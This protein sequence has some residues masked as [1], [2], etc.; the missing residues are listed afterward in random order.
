MTWQ[1]HRLSLVGA[2]AV[3]VLTVTSTIAFLV[4]GGTW[5]F[6]QRMQ[7]P[8]R[9]GDLGFGTAG[10]D[11]L[12]LWLMLAAIA[13]TFVVPTLLSTTA[14]AAVVGAAGRERRLAVLRLVGLS[15]RDI[16]AMT[17]LETG[18]QAVMGITLGFLIS[19][20]I[21][22]LFSA[23]SFQNT[24]IG[25]RELYLPWWGY[26]AVAAMVLLLALSAAYLGMRR[27]RVTPLGVAKRQVSPMLKRW[28]LVVFLLIAIPG[29][30]F[31]SH[32]SFSAAAGVVIATLTFLFLVVSAVNLVCP[33]I[34]QL[35]ARIMAL[36][37]GKAHFVATQRVLFDAKAVW[38]RSSATALFGL[39]AGYL[40]ISPLGNDALS[41]IYSQDP[42]SD[43]IFRD[44]STGALLTLGFGFVIM[45]V[46][47]FLGQVSEVFEHAELARSLQRM[48]VSRSFQTRV[49]LVEVMGPIVLVSLFGF[50]MGVFLGMAMVFNAAGDEV[51]WGM[52][53]LNAFI[54]LSVGW[55]ATMLAIALAEPLRSRLLHASAR[56]ND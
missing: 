33:Y 9:I 24:P 23:L 34:L 25:M 35:V 36:L 50:G 18:G 10:N 39:L 48:G 56:R 19:V 51:N 13:C 55:L 47:L 21:V 20:L 6:Y 49:A 29:Y 17:V 22:P 42:S 54:F 4:C 11:G 46:S 53:A 15:A 28:R 16:T 31:I 45:A 40:V 8:E 1:L 37:P 41:T 32:F 5:M 12:G 38:R 30:F 52:R 3:M 43:V 14:Q 2:L 26:V 7:H 44:V 27:V